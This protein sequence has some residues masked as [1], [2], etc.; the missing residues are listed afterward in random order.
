METLHIS[1]IG[2][3]G[4]DAFPVA[5]S[6]LSDHAAQLLIFGG[7][8]PAFG[9]GSGVEGRSGGTVIERDVLGRG[10]LFGVEGGKWVLL[11]EFGVGLLGGE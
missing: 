10:V 11:T 2:E 8:P 3:V 4:G 9:V 1:A 5:G 7:G 6:K